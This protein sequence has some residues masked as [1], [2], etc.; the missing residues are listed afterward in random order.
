[1]LASGHHRPASV[2][3]GEILVLLDFHMVPW[4]GA[5]SDAIGQQ[6]PRATFADEHVSDALVLVLVV[7]RLLMGA[8]LKLWRRVRL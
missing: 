4:S 3:L 2:D 1:M 8:W 7:I 5:R 6:G